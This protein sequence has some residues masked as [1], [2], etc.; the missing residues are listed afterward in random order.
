[1]RHN[2]KYG[3]PIVGSWWFGFTSYE[4]DPQGEWAAAYCLGCGRNVGLSGLIRRFIRWWR[5]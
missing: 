5:R 1:M 4:D 2:C 3:D